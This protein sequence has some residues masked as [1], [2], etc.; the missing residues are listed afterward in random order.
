MPAPGCL[1]TN[2]PPG[3]CPAICHSS[4]PIL[5]AVNSS[6]PAAIQTPA[7]CQALARGRRPSSMLPLPSPSGETILEARNDTQP[8]RRRSPDAL[9]T[10]YPQPPRQTSHRLWTT[11]A[12]PSTEKT[13]RA[14]GTRAR[15]CGPPRSGELRYGTG[16]AGQMV[17]KP[18]IGGSQPRARSW[19]S[20]LFRAV[21]IPVS[22]HGSYP[23]GLAGPGS[24][25]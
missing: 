8:A 15:R 11:R 18:D 20:P 24:L 2:Q 9:C 12:R 23:M 3:Q 5:A 13:R 1:T 7:I 10:R 25:S 4:R 19:W 16:L 22:S 21:D 6:A 17:R 14:P